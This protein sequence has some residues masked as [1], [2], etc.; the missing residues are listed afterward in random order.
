MRTRHIV[1]R[2][3]RRGLRIRVEKADGALLVEDLSDAERRGGEIVWERSAPPGT[4]YY[5]LGARADAS[6]DLRGKSV[7]AAVPLLVSTAGYGEYQAAPGNYLFDLTAPDRY[8]VRVRQA[9]GLDSYL[10]Y[11]PTPKEIFEEHAIVRAPVEAAPSRHFGPRRPAL[12]VRGG[13]SWSTLRDALLRM[14][15]ASLSGALAPG[16]DLSPYAGVEEDL[17][18]RAAQLGALAPILLAPDETTPP[19]RSRLV[20]VFEAYAEEARERGYPLLRALPFQFPGDPEAA[21]HSDLFLL[22]DELLVAPIYTPE[23]ARSVY[24]PMGQ[25]TRLDTNER[26]PG[27]REVTAAGPELPVF[28]RNGSIVPL[29]GRVMELHYFPRLAGEFF[30]F[31]Q[32]SNDWTQVHAGPAGDLIRLEIESKEG[33]DYEWVVHHLDRPR[34]AGFEGRFYTEARNRAGLLPES[35]HYDAERKNLHVRVRVGAGEDRIINVWFE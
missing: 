35:W 7:E 15:H 12:P 14:V 33:R 34:R 5:G 11:G 28:A 19:L 13:G 27:R 8:R 3:A 25:W 9:G 26:F 20:P 10:Y 4:R 30:L 1:L 6:L 17:H 23:G 18:R 32:A 21:R 29:A 24:L 22:G 31:E 16:F 2:I